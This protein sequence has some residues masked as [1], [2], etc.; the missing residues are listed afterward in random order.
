MIIKTSKN[1]DFLIDS[2]SEDHTKN[3]PAGKGI[4]IFTTSDKFLDAYGNNFVG[5]AINNWFDKEFLKENLQLCILIV[6]LRHFYDCSCT[7][8]KRI[9]NL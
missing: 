6:T 5:P 8:G 4:I 2:Y 9:Y 1:I 7:V 3:Y